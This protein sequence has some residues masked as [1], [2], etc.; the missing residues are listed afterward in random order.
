MNCIYSSVNHTP[1]KRLSEIPS[2]LQQTATHTS[3]ALSPWGVVS[4]PVFGEPR[5]KLF[6]PSRTFFCFLMLLSVFPLFR[7]RTGLVNH[8]FKVLVER[9]GP[10]ELW[11]ELR[12]GWGCKLATE[13]DLPP[14]SLE[15]TEYASGRK[16]RRWEIIPAP[17]LFP[18]AHQALGSPKYENTS[19]LDERFCVYTRTLGKLYCTPERNMPC[20]R[21]FSRSYTLL[22]FPTILSVLMKDHRQQSYLVCDESLNF[23]LSAE[24]L[25]FFPQISLWIARKKISR[26]SRLLQETWQPPTLC[27][28]LI[29]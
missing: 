21:H 27:Q 8:F 7:R 28:V 4:S 22:S 23:M 26:K 9:L 6:L 11:I 14:L 1:Q 25:S 13:S 3:S 17:T 15:D 10:G 12:D 16:Q 24:F 2:F 29:P 5:S 20:N 19:C 18:R